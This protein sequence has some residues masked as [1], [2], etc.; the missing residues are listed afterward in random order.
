MKAIYNPSFLIYV[1]YCNMGDFQHYC[2]FIGN[3]FS[4]HMLPLQKCVNQFK[5]PNILL[6]DK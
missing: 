4:L 3:A 6:I 2:C 1:A 5:E